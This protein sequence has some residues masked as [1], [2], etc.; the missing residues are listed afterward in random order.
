[1]KLNSKLRAAFAGALTLGLLASG[2]GSA[3]AAPG[4]ALN[5]QSTGSKGAFFL[6]DA[7]TA[8][9]A[10]SADPKTPRVYTRDEALI[11]S[12]SSSDVQDEINPSATRPVTGAPSFT[13]VYRFISLKTAADV[14]GGTATWKA[15]SIDRMLAGDKSTSA[16][17]RPH[18]CTSG[19]PSPGRPGARRTGK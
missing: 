2:A 3:F 15:F 7:N 4:D 11:A 17:R 13:S 12:A 16:P 9:S 18:R 1:M 6:W 19:R 10:E 14:A 5:P 8:E